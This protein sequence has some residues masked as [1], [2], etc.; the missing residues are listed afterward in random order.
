MRL[1]IR[2][3]SAALALF[4]GLLPAAAQ[5]RVYRVG[6]LS[7]GREILSL[8]R[9]F[10]PELA[11]Q[12]LVEGRNLQ[13]VGGFADGALDKLAELARDLVA[14]PVDVIVAVSAPAIRAAR[15]ASRTTPIVM[16]FVDHDP[17][18]SGFIE[19]YARP[20]TNVTGVAML[21]AEADA[22]RIELLAQAFPGR[23]LALLASS[24]FEMPSLIAARRVAEAAGVDLSIVSALDRAAFPR[25]FA[26]IAE[27][28]AAAVVIQSSPVFANN[29]D[30]LAADAAAARLPVLCVWRE[31][32][33][34]GC[35]A[36]FGPSI[37]TLDRRAANYVVKILAGQSP[38]T[39]PVEQAAT[40]ELVINQRAARSI[41]LDVPPSLLARAD[42]VIE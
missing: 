11:R 30:A 39:L 23:R 27:A 36:S 14:V 15:D 19:S 37:D 5:D 42:E 29:M 17:V 10:A 25:A 2:L 18:L 41:G 28:G 21:A 33:E 31:M 34:A 3:A 1:V 22:K 38:A 32:A 7:P 12:G 20:G 8:R 35:F 40:F 4:C 26:T 9:S 24:T 13:F 16:R 6:L